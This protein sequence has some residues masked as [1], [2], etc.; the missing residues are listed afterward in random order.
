MNIQVTEDDIEQ[1]VPFDPCR[2]PVALA[3]KRATRRRH[4]IVGE[5]AL[6]IGRL[7]Y[8]TPHELRRFIEGFDLGR[9]V[10]PFSFDIKGLPRF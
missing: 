4:I 9:T 3:I 6:E 10:S 2:C 8:H 7:R 1:G 5:S